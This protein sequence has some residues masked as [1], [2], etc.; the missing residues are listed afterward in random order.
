MQKA[1][2]CGR[3]LGPDLKDCLS[4][5]TLSYVAAWREHARCDLTMLHRCCYAQTFYVDK[6]LR[7]FILLSIFQ[8]LLFIVSITGLAR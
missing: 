8:V 6:G 4:G 2:D 5:G 1:L 3:W 7:E